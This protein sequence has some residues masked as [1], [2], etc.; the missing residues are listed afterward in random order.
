M[1][2]SSYSIDS[3]SVCS[4]V[5]SSSDTG[6]KD[7]IGTCCM[8]MHMYVLHIGYFAVPYLSFILAVLLV[9]VQET[10]LC[11]YRRTGALS[12]I[13]ESRMVSAGRREQLS[14]TL[15]ENL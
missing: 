5:V 13:A 1:M 3:C 6:H 11:V 12:M 4:A 9:H 7:L 8:M 10:V 14:H 2:I 15:P